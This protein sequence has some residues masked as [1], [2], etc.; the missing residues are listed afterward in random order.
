MRSNSQEPKWLSIQE[1][2]NHLG[3]HK[4]TIRNLLLSGKLPAT[5][6]SSR[7]IRVALT[8]LEAF[9]KA[10]EGGEQGQWKTSA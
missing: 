5:R 3:V 7:V 4:N 1:C 8:D 2:A 6:Y 9:G 10:F